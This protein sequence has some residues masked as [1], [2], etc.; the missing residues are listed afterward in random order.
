YKEIIPMEK[1]VVSDY[2]SDEEGN[3]VDPTT[4]GMSPD[5]PEEMNVVVLFEDIENGKTKLSIIYSPETETDYKAMLTSGMQE[6]WSTSLDKFAE[7]LK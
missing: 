1:L 4:M 7:I 5:M 2:F 3:K 6:G